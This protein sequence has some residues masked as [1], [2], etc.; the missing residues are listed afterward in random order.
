MA[1][2]HV[3][4]A[5]A[6]I[7]G[8]S[9][10]WWLK[11]AGFRVTVL[12][13]DPSPGGTMKTISENGWLVERGPNSALETT[14]LIREILEGLGIMNER[15]YAD[16]AASNRYIVRSGR[17]HALPMS[18]GKFLSSGL[19]TARGK[20]RLLGEPFAGRAAKEESIAQFVTRR[21][22]GEFLDYAINPFVAGVYA[23]SPERLSVRA[24]FPK[25]Y[26]LE[27]KYGGLLIGALRSR[28]ERKKRKEV[29]KDRARL[30]SFI[31]GM[32][33]FP[34][35]LASALGDSVRY[36]MP[37]R[38]IIPMRAGAS[39]IY[40]V[41]AGE[42]ETIE[43]DAVVLSTPARA[44]ASIIRPID[45]ALAEILSSIHYPPVAEVFLGFRK[46][47]VARTL[48]GFGFLV[49]E[50]ERRN[51]L[52][53]IWASTLFPGRAPEGHA[54]LVSF[55]GGSRQ[56]DL[57]SLPDDEL[58]STVLADLKPL[59]GLAADPV[60]TRIVR[61]REAIPQYELGYKRKTDAMEMF[62]KNFR[63][64]FLCGN[65][66]G[67]IAVGDCVMSARRTADA[68]QALFS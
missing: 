65:Y 44:A 39:P 20:L 29:A 35:A 51:I 3:V 48:D 59:M 19:W 37:V 1:Q 38:H 40:H 67:G 11:R 41:A 42:G 14:P 34:A 57:A 61:W 15:V 52:G 24:A 46:G 45:P 50:V 2:K 32:S 6:G 68:I 66:R 63:G 21:L 13:Q 5:G 36:G 12:E 9:T 28:N 25:L 23:G 62:E 56:P 30:F 4:V 53:C 26:A 31:D 60:Y 58:V 10:A 49:P 22:G 17:L 16:D 18:P 64:A 8:L 47:D 54:A 7:S 27:E 33:V 43:A 55:V